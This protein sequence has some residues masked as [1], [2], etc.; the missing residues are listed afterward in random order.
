MGMPRPL[1]NARRVER[2]DL[3]AGR[4]RRRSVPLD[5]P[6]QRRVPPTPASATTAARHAARPRPPP[7]PG[8]SAPPR[9]DAGGPARPG[10]RRRSAG[11]LCGP[12]TRTARPPP[13]LPARPPPGAGHPRAPG[14]R[15][16]ARNGS[17]SLRTSQAVGGSS[18][19]GSETPASISAA[20]AREA[21]DSVPRTPTEASGWGRLRSP[22]TTRSAASSALRQARASAERSSRQP[23]L[24]QGGQQPAYAVGVGRQHPSRWVDTDLQARGIPADDVEAGPQRRPRGQVGQHHGRRV[25]QAAIGPLGS[26]TG[27]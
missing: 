9:G 5:E 13:A 6:D 24:A 17:P 15:S 22:S 19:R 4:P 10:G 12:A 25:T 21:S 16:G 3:V 7:P 1:V 2:P 14:R 8:R 26:S 18:P 20:R 11:R 23:S 27:T